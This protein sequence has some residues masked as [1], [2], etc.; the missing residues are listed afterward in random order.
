MTQVSLVIGQA[1]TGKTTWLIEKVK[2]QA[3]GMLSF[4]HQSLLA[5]T[6]MHGARRRVE[7]K[8]RESSPGIRCSVATID[9]FALSILNRWRTALGWSKPIQSVSAEADFAEGTFAIK[10]DFG[11]VLAAATH[12]LEY[13]TVRRIIGASY[14]LIV[15]DEFQD[16]HGPLLEFVK[17]LSSCSTLFLAADDFQLLDNSTVG[18]PAVEWVT[19]LDG[20]VILD[21]VEI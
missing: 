1:G 11:R 4:E 2:D 8:L 19:A 15:I 7:M 21:L 6:R 14:P 10:A 5:I 18:C 12:L 13:S 17:V 9:G 16:C 3:P 20:G